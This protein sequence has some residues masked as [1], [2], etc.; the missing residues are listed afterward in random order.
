MIITVFIS[1]LGFVMLYYGGELL[2]RSSVNLALKLNIST[3]VVGLTVVSFA[4]SSPELFISLQSVLDHRSSIA[5]GNTIG[6]NIAN[7]TLVLGISAIIY[8]V[9]ISQMN[10]KLNVPVMVLSTLFLG[11]VLYFLNSIT[12]LVGIFF[13]LFLI[14]ILIL[15]VKKSRIEY[16]KK[17][18][19]II[20]ENKVFTI[21]F[22]FYFFLFYC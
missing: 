18:N 13:I 10:L 3:L 2:V 9:R 19:Q 6:S 4:T 5:L 11:L 14:V 7:I 17:N 22:L 12:F 21:V 8:N 16:K 1:L 20:L 15:I